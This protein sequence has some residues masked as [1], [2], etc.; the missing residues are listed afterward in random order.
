M[1]LWSKLFGG[2]AGGGD[3]KPEAKSE[4]YK[5]FRIMAEPQSGEGGYRVGARIE[6]EIGGEVK[7]HHLLRA[8][9]ARLYC[10]S[11][12]ST[13]PPGFTFPLVG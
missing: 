1:S 2:G 11:A 4:I 13:V 10:D 7:V 3:A 12:L 5:G 6:K 9:A 8:D